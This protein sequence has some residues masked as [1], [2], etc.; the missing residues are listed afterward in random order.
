MV[1]GLKRS[2]PGDCT[3]SA[4]ELTWN[5]RSV[6]SGK[7]MEFAF[8]REC[9]GKARKLMTP[10]KQEGVFYVRK[11]LVY[12]RSLDGFGAHRQS[13]LDPDRYLGRAGCNP[14]WRC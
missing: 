14:G 5:K 1:E 12:R 2:T 11:H 8:S 7:A 6:K 10:S 9:G 13:D 4:F 3:A